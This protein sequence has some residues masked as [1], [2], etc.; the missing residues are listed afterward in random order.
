M[1]TIFLS[2]LSGLTSQLK[3]INIKHYQ[4]LN[5]KTVELINKVKRFYFFFVAASHFYEIFGLN[6]V[7]YIYEFY[8]N[9][10]VLLH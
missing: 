5:I 8:L 7:I 2:D 4:P 6:S 3:Y 10:K 1:V 9:G